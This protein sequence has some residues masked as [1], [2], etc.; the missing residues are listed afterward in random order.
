MLEEDVELQ[1]F[2][3]TAGDNVTEYSFWEVVGQFLIKLNMDW[4]YGPAIIFL[5]IYPSELKTTSTQKP[6]YEW[7]HQLYTQLLKP[8]GNWDVFQQVN[9]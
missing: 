3:L 4:L 2:S 1:E 6:A 7:I 9:G 8:G 5:C